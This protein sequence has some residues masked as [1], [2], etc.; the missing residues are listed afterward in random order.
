MSDYLI[1]FIG[2]LI[3]MALLIAVRSELIR[4]SSKY[5][6]GFGDAFRVYTTKYTGPMIVGAIIILSAMFILPDLLANSE[7]ITEDGTTD[8]NAKIALVLNWLRPASIALGVIS[9][10]LGF[11]IVRKGDHYLRQEE[12]KIKE[13][14]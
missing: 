4:R 14:P 10:G 2:G 3:G 12:I 7:I 9:Q 6:L 13:K 11:L 5:E 8:Y 1:I